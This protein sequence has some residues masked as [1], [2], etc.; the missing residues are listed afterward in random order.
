MGAIEDAGFRGV[1]LIAK[2]AG[3]DARGE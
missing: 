3:G 1:G 2:P